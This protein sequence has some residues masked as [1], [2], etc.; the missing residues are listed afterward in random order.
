MGQPGPC[1]WGWLTCSADTTRSPAHTW[2]HLRSPALV[3]LLSPI[4][5]T[6]FMGPLPPAHTAIWATDRSQ[7]VTQQCEGEMRGQ[8]R[9]AAGPPPQVSPSEA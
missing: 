1:A 4:Y 5:C 3:H 7:V 9:G 2:A 8:N 6:V